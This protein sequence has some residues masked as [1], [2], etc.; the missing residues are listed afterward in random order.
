[1]KETLKNKRTIK[2]KDNIVKIDN[3]GE[4]INNIRAMLQN[5]GNGNNKLLDKQKS[6]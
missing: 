5:M 3:L 2:Q 1:M 4:K 6:K